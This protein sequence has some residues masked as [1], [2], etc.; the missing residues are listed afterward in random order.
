MSEQV[1]PHDTPLPKNW[2]PG[3]LAPLNRYCPVCLVF[4]IH[5]RHEMY[6]DMIRCTRCNLARQNVAVKR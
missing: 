1:K 5:Q 4:T 3:E 6:F 2:K